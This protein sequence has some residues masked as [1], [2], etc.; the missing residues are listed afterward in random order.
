[1]IGGVILNIYSLIF[2]IVL[3][4]IFFTKPKTHNKEVEIYSRLLIISLLMNAS[5]LFIS[6]AVLLN[7]SNIIL[8][9][10][11]K[12]YLIFLDLW[13][14]YLT[15]YVISIVFYKDKEAKKSKKGIYFISILCSLLIL[16]LP[17][18]INNVNNE[19]MV[20]GLSII[21]SYLIF[22]IGF[23]SQIVMILTDMKNARNKKFIPVYL[24]AIL[25]V[26]SVIIIMS[27]PILNYIINP[28][29]IFII[30]VMF[31]TIE[32]PDMRMIEE[33]AQNR[34]LIEEGIEEKANILFEISQEVRNP[35]YRIK[36]ISNDVTNNDTKEELKN[37]ITTINNEA[38][39]VSLFI[40]KALD[41]TSINPKTM[42][43]YSNTYNPNSIFESIKFKVKEKNPNIDFD[44][45][46]SKSLPKELY[47]D[48]VKLKQIMSS[49][50]EYSIKRT[51]K[52]FIEVKV[53]C[54]NKYDVCR[55]IIFI[56]DSGKSLNL[57]TIN[58]I[59][60][61]KF[62][63]D[64]DQNDPNKLIVSM[65]IVNS[66][67]KDLGGYLM[68]NS[69]EN[70]STEFKVVLDQKIKIDSDKNPS[71]FKLLVNKYLNNKKM[72]VVS[73]NSDLLKKFKSLNSDFTI[74]TL[75]ITNDLIEN[76]KNGEKYDLIILDDEMKNDSGYAT[77]MKLKSI[78]G[79]KTPVIVLLNDDK[80]SIKEQYLNDGFKDFIMINNFKEDIKKINKY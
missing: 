22:F 60:N 39:Q 62:K 58:D 49:I 79:F 46:V 17:I 34:N 2:I 65:N 23:I 71:N 16:F 69:E 57:G 28:I 44:L 48:Y 74:S 18:K 25:G 50:I 41:I 15:Y 59:L 1:M 51:S 77:L 30:F 70:K 42:K 3:N 72:V 29:L 52:G 40:D 78:P 8:I 75:M 67:V 35:I 31:N 76:V 12:V 63:D 6:I 4:I 73:H 36:N 7:L 27:N 68:I 37:K 56:T 55:L 61:S 10:V 20:N 64:S 38:K 19:V 11:N 9:L 14:I 45:I 24:L 32:N 66:M 43:E 33:L 53:N 80:K 47:G 26:T 5:G 54:I 13:I 21:T